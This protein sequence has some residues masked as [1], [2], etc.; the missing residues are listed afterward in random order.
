MYLGDAPNSKLQ[1]IHKENYHYSVEGSVREAERNYQ[2]V[3][4]KNQVNKK[5]LTT[6]LW[7]SYDNQRVEKTIQI[8]QR[9]PVNK[10]RINANDVDLGTMINNQNKRY[11]H[12]EMTIRCDQNATVKVSTTP[13]ILELTKGANSKITLPTSGLSLKLMEAR[14]PSYP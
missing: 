14:R 7:C 1:Q 9:P 4:N 3:G 6:A 13:T 10:C 11:E 2:I 12:R 5:W 8:V